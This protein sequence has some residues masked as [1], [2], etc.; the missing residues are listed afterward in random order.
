MKALKPHECG[1]GVRGFFLRKAVPKLP[2][3]SVLIYYE[4]RKIKFHILLH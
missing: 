1:V 3:P 2:A 4:S